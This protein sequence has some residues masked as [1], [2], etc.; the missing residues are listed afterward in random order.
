MNK[1]ISSFFELQVVFSMCPKLF[2][3][4]KNWLMKQKP[5]TEVYCTELITPYT[6]TPYAVVEQERVKHAPVLHKQCSDITL[7]VL[8]DI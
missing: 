1:K 2:P 6:M 7:K 8:H 3:N 4:D 5:C